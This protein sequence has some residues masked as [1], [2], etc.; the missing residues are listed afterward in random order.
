MK[1]GRLARLEKVELNNEKEELT[2]TIAK[3]EEIINNVDKRKEIYLNRFNAFVKKYGKQ[4]RRTEL[5]HI[6][7]SKEE[8]EAQ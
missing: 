6:E 3:C 4:D 8:K 7:V 5:T 1:L 2:S